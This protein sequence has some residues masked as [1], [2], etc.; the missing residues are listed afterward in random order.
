MRQ[1]EQTQTHS[2]KNKFDQSKIKSPRV[3]QC[4]GLGGG[5]TLTWRAFNA[6]S[7]KTNLNSF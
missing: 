6:S 1:I 4:V 3:T 2:I 7:L 5:V